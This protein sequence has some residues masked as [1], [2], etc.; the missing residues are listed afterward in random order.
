M[1]FLFLLA[2]FML[3]SVAPATAQ[4]VRIELGQSRLPINQYFT[5]SARLQDQ[6]LKDI[7]AFPDIEG[8][9]KS[10]KFS[11]TKTIIVGGKTTV[12]LTV[13]QNYAAF[14][15]GEFELKPFAM[16]VNGQV[17][18]SKGTTIQVL[19]MATNPQSPDPTIAEA[20]AEEEIEAEQE[21]VDMEDNAFLTL[22][23]SKKEVFVGEGV[24]VVLYFYLANEDQRLLDFYDF[25]NQLTSILKQLKQPNVWEETFEIGE[26]TPEQ[27]SISD[28]P[29]LRFKLYEAVLYPLNKEPLVFPPLSLRMIKYKVAK[30]PGLLA[31]D[32]LEGYKTFR[33][34]ERSIVVKELPPHPLRDV[35]PVGAYSLNEEVNKSNV[36]V[37]KSIKYQFEIVG[38]GNLA[39]IMAPEP[40][41]VPG[42]EF[43]P[44]DLSQN[45][46][47]R[48]G[49][50]TGAKTFIYPA[51][52]RQP[53]YY[54]LSDAF[55]WVFFNPE[56]AVYDTLRPELVVRVTGES[57]RD[58]LIL[59]RNLGT[60]Y[61]IIKNEE[62]TLVSLHYVDEIKRYTNIVLLVLL[63][64][65]AF[66]FLRTKHK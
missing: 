46:T 21:F 47:R 14:E 15:E 22:Y 28:K 57:D 61:N 59:S 36:S 39:A 8:F 49:R 32:R 13:T 66:V 52:A 4:Q 63:V 64:V 43:Y 1:R 18:Q 53:G 62:N 37:N 65:S 51:I 35:V 42:L 56:T 38:E 24:G 55:D 41:P 12:I 58:D 29:F 34:R 60:F 25:A 11:S 54:S 23:T 27:V 50:I 5:I 44:S 26:I 10:T 33:A 17:V 2:F 20:E 16:K 19:P 9:K 30:N 3:A 31:E 48:D 7:S 6:E 45:I 40:V